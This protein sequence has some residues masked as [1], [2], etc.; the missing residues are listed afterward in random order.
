MNQ[1]F[2]AFCL[3]HFPQSNV[4]EVALFSSFPYARD[5]LTN[6][7]EI[8]VNYSCKLFDIVNFVNYKSDFTSLILRL[9]II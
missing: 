6:A 1:I 5:S 8:F 4:K 9:K 2:I 3:V 7:P